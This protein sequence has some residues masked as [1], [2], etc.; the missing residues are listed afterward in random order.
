MSDSKKIKKKTSEIDDNLLSKEKKEKKEKREKKD[1]KEKPTQ[2]DLPKPTQEDLPKPTQ[3]DLPK[4]TQ[5]D[6]PKPT[7]EDL[8][9]PESVVIQY[10]TEIQ[11]LRRSLAEKYRNAGQEVKPQIKLCDDCNQ[12]IYSSQ[13]CQMSGILHNKNKIMIG[14]KFFD[15]DKTAF[16]SGELISAI[17][18]MRVK[19]QVARTKKTQI[20]FDSINIFQSFVTQNNWKIQRYGIMYGKYDIAQNL[21][22]V[23][24]IYEPEQLN[25]Q[26]SFKL[27]FTKESMLKEKQV[28]KLASYLGLQRVGIILTHLPRN[29]ND[30]VV[31]GKELMLIAK[32]QS[33]FGDCCVLLS[34]SP[35]IKSKEIEA[36]VWQASEQC[37]N[38]YQMG[39]FSEENYKFDDKYL[40]TTQPLEVSQDEKDEKGK[41]ICAIKKPSNMIDTHWMIAPVAIEQFNSDIICNKFIRINRPENLT[42]PPNFNNLAIFLET[43]KKA[44]KLPFP[45]RLKDFHVLIFLMQ[46]IFDINSDMPHIIE[47]IKKNDED[48]L[49][50]FRKIMKEKMMARMD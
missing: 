11:K 44:K 2:E 49:K 45:Q 37:V 39:M 1:K 26:D 3:E 20:D 10:E 34:L 7:Q 47:A 32:E 16:T 46:N 12:D 33:K 13:I 29:E 38:L 23:H 5:E 22:S 27:I 6:L 42:P 19:W 15:K 50:V 21:V 9:K 4:P 28:D 35:N 8:P 36:H 40:I 18:A 41:T 43:Q 48:G 14:G 31:S 17:D 24:T 25:S 30:F